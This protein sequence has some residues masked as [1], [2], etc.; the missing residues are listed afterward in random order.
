[1]TKVKYRYNHETCTYEPIFHSGSVWTK[2]I[3]MFMTLA[4]T[5]A[6]SGVYWYNQNYPSID[7][8]KLELENEILLTQ[9]SVLNDKIN[10]ISSQLAELEFVDDF[11]YRTV[12]DLPKLD[13][14]IRFGGTGGHEVFLLPHEELPLIM[15]SYDKMKR[16]KN[17]LVVEKQSLDEIEKTI[18][19]KE[20]MMVTRPAMMPINNEQLT[21]FNTI[22]GM[23]LHPILGDWRL[24]KGLDLTAPTGT[25]VYASGNGIITYA[26]WLGGLGNAIIINHGF[27]FVSRYGHL[28]KFNIVNGQRVKRGDLIGFVGN[29]G[30]STNSHLHYE[31]LYRNKHVNPIDFMYR[32]LKQEEYEKLLSDK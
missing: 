2:R 25:P 13:S 23:R 27:G 10:S 17:R 29:T 18:S 4:L 15:N 1:M 32:D 26:S 9:W 11:N 6:S 12:L 7:E 14:S 3:L 22:Y 28:S 21:R 24:H 5:I 16:I 8:Q 19:Y 31:I 20:Q 30:L